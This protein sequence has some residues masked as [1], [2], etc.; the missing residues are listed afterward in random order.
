MLQAL[1]EA[2]WTWASPM[3]L[4]LSYLALALAMAAAARGLSPVSMTP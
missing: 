1:P 4:V 2:P 3:R